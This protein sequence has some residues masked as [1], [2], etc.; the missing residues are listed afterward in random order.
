MNEFKDLLSEYICELHIIRSNAKI[1][2]KLS[3]SNLRSFFESQKEID[4]KI[5][6]LCIKKD[7]K[8]ILEKYNF[9]EKLKLILDSESIPY[10]SNEKELRVNMKNL[11]INIFGYLY[12][13]KHRTMY[14]DQGNMIIPYS[15][16]SDVISFV[17]DNLE[18]SEKELILLYKLKD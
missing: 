14:I 2:E 12:M 17:I 18:M 5:E 3:M 7:L 6:D 9:T 15:G 10:N 13:I 1:L 16:N 4:D 11:E 8:T